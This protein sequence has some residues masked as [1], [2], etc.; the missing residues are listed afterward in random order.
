VRTR[1]L[2]VP[3]EGPALVLLHGFSDSADTWRAL[4]GRLA[5]SRRRAIAIDLP[6]F[7]AADDAQP[8]AVFPQFEAV[9]AA[10]MALASG[11]S[12]R[13]PVLVG[14]SMGG[15]VSLFVANRRASELAGVVPVCSAGIAHPLW[16]RALAAPVVSR[17]LPV[18]GL[19]PLRQSLR[20]PLGR[21]VAATRTDDLSEH[22][23]RHL[24]HLNRARLAHHVSIVGRLLHEQDYPLDTRTITCPVM[25]VWGA[26][27]RVVGSA[28]QRRKVLRLSC[29]VPNAR[30]EVLSA[31]GHVPHLEAPGRL[32]AL[33]DDFSPTAA[34]ARP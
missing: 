11:P 16:V 4:L 31:C 6:G 1:V 15:A 29:Q 33:L 10:A 13:P 18:L 34:P 23:P 2:E 3:G 12:G 22:L 19:R 5:R 21:F 32:L 17:V 30:C 26:A 9:V 8:G 28:S 14:N 27:D 25:F 24:A 20:R 7:G